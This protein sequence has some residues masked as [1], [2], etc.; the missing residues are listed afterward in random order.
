METDL[1]ALFRQTHHGD[2]ETVPGVRLHDILDQL[3]A[4]CARLFPP[5]GGLVLAHEADRA[6]GVELCVPVA[7]NASARQTAAQGVAVPA[8]LHPAGHRGRPAGVVDRADG[9]ALR[10]APEP[11]DGRRRRP[12]L[13]DDVLHLLLGQPHL[14]RA[15]RPERPDAPAVAAGQLR[16]LALLPQMPVDAVLH[17]RHP[18]HGGGGA[19]VDIAAAAEHVHA[20]LLPRQIRDHARLD[21]GVVGNVEDVPL[22][23][24]KR[25]ADQLAEHVR[26][27]V[28][29]QLQRLKIAFLDKLADETEPGEMVLRQIL[30]LDKPPRP[31]SGAARAVIL[32]QPAHAPV[33]AH[34]ALHGLVFGDAGFPQL[35]PQL[36]HAPRR[37]V[38][39]LVLQLQ[40]RG[41]VQAVRAHAGGLQPVLELRH[42]VR[43]LQSREPL[44]FGHVPCRECLVLRNG[45][46]HKLGVDPDAALVDPRVQRPYLPLKVRHGE[47]PQPPVNGLLDL[48]VPLA[49]GLEPLPLVRRM[50][51]QIPR[52]PAVGDGGLARLAEIRYERRALPDLL[53]PQL[54]RGAGGVQTERQ[55]VHRRQDH[56]VLPLLRRQV[57]AQI[58]RQ[59]GPLKSAV[60]GD[61][62][63]VGVGYP[64]D[65]GG[66]RR[67]LCRRALIR[68][69][70]P[71]GHIDHLHR[72]V[73]PD[74]GQQQDLKVRGLRILE[75]PGLGDIGAAV[76]LQ[77]D[78]QPALS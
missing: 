56:R 18:E 46:R 29:A 48:Y 11:R 26:H 55:T 24:H 58:P 65:H 14:V 12:P 62:H 8:V 61:L 7:Q 50:L 32:Q 66:K 70:F 77:V 17:D 67:R 28:K 78:E 36:Q 27:A 16:D 52:P 41:L 57:A 25:R 42:A 6:V 33:G 20:P 39:G 45:C 71:A 22:P 15:E 53:I 76:R 43:I 49:V 10:V 2:G 37:G 59:T 31:T 72:P 3:A 13:R 64:G 4:P 9:G 38:C 68:H 34:G 5:A 44:H 21:G 19:A 54:Q 1:P 40:H 73:V 60:V 47:A 23:G 75:G 74:E 30:N 69:R 51:R 35:L 63:R